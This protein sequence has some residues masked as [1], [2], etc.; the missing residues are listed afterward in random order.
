MT[1]TTKHMRSGI[2][3]LILTLVAALVLLYI[4]VDSNGTA[5]LGGY[6]F[7]AL[8]G[9]AITKAVMSFRAPRREDHQSN[10]REEPPR[11][12]GG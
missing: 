5:A 12:E 9:A 3:T 8:S 2:L 11:T 1:E 7:G 6:F 4:V 10:L